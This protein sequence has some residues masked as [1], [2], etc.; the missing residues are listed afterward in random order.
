MGILKILEIG[1]EYLCRPCENST[2]EQLRHDCPSAA[3]ATAVVPPV[4]VLVSVL[5]SV[6]VSVL[7]RP[8]AQI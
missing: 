8:A 4:S 5:G 3:A 7:V 2:G 1:M 6:S